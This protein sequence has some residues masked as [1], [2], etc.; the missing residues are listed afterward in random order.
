MLYVVTIPLV[1]SQDRRRETDVEWKRRVMVQVLCR[2]KTA[3]S[4][5][6]DSSHNRKRLRKRED[7]KIILIYRD[8][9]ASSVHI[10]DRAP[11]YLLTIFY[12]NR[13]TIQA[14]RNVVIYLNTALTHNKFTLIVLKIQAEVYG[15]NK[16]STAEEFSY[17]WCKGGAQ[18]HVE[19]VEDH[20]HFSMLLVLYSYTDSSLPS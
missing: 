16:Q 9:G 3:K 12:K 8:W 15:E 6:R 13:R 19:I 5:S 11:L 4:A 17:T 2:R 10:D 7:E 20:N 1:K 14:C 18:S